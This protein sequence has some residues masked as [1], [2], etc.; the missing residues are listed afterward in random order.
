MICM[1][2]RVKKV[3]S[4]QKG[5]QK[6][7]KCFNVIAG[8]SQLNGAVCHTPLLCDPTHQMARSHR[9]AV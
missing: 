7:H 1:Q 9:F 5:A 3:L 6:V 2:N 4:A 8:A